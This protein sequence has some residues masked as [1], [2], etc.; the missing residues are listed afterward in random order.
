MYSYTVRV[1]KYICVYLYVFV[2]IYVGTYALHTPFTTQTKV[3]YSEIQYLANVKSFIKKH[4]TQ[5]IK[6]KLHIGS[7]SF[8]PDI[9][10]PR[11]MENAVRD[12]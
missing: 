9:Q 5:N 10:K 2:C 7:K 3:L 8:R 11:Q 6:N 12:I 1:H 4:R